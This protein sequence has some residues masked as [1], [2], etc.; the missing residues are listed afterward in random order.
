MLS[1][2]AIELCDCCGMLVLYMHVCR[3]TVQA[4]VV[5]HTLLQT[6]LEKDLW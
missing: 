1:G 5:M 4:H 2:I 3:P 6:T